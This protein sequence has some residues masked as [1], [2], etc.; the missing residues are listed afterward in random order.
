[1]ALDVQDRSGYMHDLTKIPSSCV[2]SE[3][4]GVTPLEANTDVL[5]LEAT[6]SSTQLSRREP[7]AGYREHIHP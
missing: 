1:M 4:P 3:M 5:H 2:H 6:T 7:V